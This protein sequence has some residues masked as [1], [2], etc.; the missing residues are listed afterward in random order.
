MDNSP[1]DIP[2]VVQDPLRRV[3]EVVE[4]PAPHR[5]HEQ[6]D[7]HGAEQERDGKEQENRVHTSSRRTVASTLDAPQMTSAL[8]SGISTAATSGFTSPATAALTARM[9][10]PIDRI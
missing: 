2:S 6:D 4:L 8:E 9:L 7:E 10:Y 3:V 5:H 1:L